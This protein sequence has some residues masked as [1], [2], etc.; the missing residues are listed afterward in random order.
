MIVFSCARRKFMDNELVLK[1]D[2]I[3]KRYRLGVM[4]R[5]PFKEIFRAGKN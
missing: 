1:V 4:G 3:K 2:N 5:E